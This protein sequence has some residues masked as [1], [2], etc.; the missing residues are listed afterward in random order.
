MNICIILTLLN[1]VPNLDVITETDCSN[2]YPNVT[3][4]MNC[5]YR[6]HCKNDEMCSNQTGYCSNGC[7]LG[8]MGPGCQYRKYFV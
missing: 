4:F 6:C 8:W 2:V 3:T 1:I 7:E 5:K